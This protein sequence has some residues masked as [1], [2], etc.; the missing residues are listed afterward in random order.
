MGL[1][2]S[3]VISYAGINE[4]NECLRHIL[5][6]VVPDTEPNF[7][8]LV[9]YY[10]NLLRKQANSTEDWITACGQGYLS[11]TEDSKGRLK[12]SVKYYQGQPD[13]TAIL[14]STK[15]S[16]FGDSVEDAP[17]AN[18]DYRTERY[19]PS[20]TKTI[21]SN[22]SDSFSIANRNKSPDSDRNSPAESFE[23][24]PSTNVSDERTEKTEEKL[25]WKYTPLSP[26]PEIQFQ[27]YDDDKPGF[28]DDYLR[29]ILAYVRRARHSQ[30]Y[31]CRRTVAT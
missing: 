16:S 27:S 31:A 15:I 29:L 21:V 22:T 17:Q 3:A 18:G 12:S 1:V 8:D 19:S 14:F 13:S 23:R 28:T 6:G 20:V 26:T 4:A 5:S 9:E 11:L 30:P 25:T 7:E 2:L 10:T 24:I